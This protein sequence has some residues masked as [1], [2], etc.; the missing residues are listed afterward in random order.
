VPYS[1][2][3]RRPLV[4]RSP[5]RVEGPARRAARAG[6]CS[7]SAAAR[8]RMPRPLSDPE[9]G[10]NKEGDLMARQDKV[11]T[12]AEITDRFRS[13]AA[14]V[15]TDYRGLSV[16]QLKELRRSLGGAVTFSVG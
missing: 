11:D 10:P 7:Q 12:V 6:E 5:D 16:A 9:F 3:R 15:L 4:A 14:A 1:S 2:A 13:A 8:M